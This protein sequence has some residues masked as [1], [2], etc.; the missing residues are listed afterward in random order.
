MIAAGLPRGAAAWIGGQ[1]RDGAWI[2]V[3]GESWSFSDWIPKPL[4]SLQP[5]HTAVRFLD[6]T[7]GGWDNA[8]PAG[9]EGVRA[10]IIEWSKDHSGVTAPAPAPP[11]LDLANLRK[12]AKVTVSQKTGKHA[13][14]IK[15]NGLALDR[16]LDLWI[17]NGL[18]E[19]V[20]ARY[21]GVVK[22]ARQTILRSGRINGDGAFPPQL[23][24]LAE[25]Y[26]IRLEKQR[27]LDTQIATSIEGDRTA[28]LEQ[29]NGALEAAHQ[30]R[31][32]DQLESLR[33]EVDSIGDTRQSFFKYLGLE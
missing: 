13:E 8:D 11:A 15:A 30:T 19:R 2:W 4:T 20:R 3:T 22:Q 33:Q 31:P 16:D 23:A 24:D 5:D 7:P 17:T 27:K 12:N 14:L 32:L 28:L 21:G 1:F 9:G 29:I 26:K 25:V 18:H 6:G 10:F